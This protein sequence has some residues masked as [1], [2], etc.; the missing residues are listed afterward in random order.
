MESGI[1][2]KCK[3]LFGQFLLT[4]KPICIV[5]DGEPVK[6]E[7]NKEFFISMEPD[8]LY[9]IAIQFPYMNR[10]CGVASI[11]V[12]VSPGEIQKY[13]YRTPLLMNLSGTIERKN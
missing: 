1:K 9:Q 3:K 4:E 11:A 12:Q 8:L 2:I 7:W 13:E 10:I 6:L 5:N